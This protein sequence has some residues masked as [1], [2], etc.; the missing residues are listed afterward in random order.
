[1]AKTDVLELAHGKA[2]VCS[3]GPEDG[4]VVL[5]IHGA[6]YPYEVLSHLV[7]P[8]VEHGYRCIRFDLYGRGFSEWDGTPLTAEILAEQVIEILDHFKIKSKI[9]LISFSNADLVANLVASRRPSQIETITWIAPSG[10]DRRTVNGFFRTLKRVP[11]MDVLLGSLMKPYFIRRMRAHQKELPSSQ[12]DLSKPIYDLAIRS[13]SENPYC[14]RAATSYLLNLPTKENIEIGAVAVA[15]AHIPVM[16][17][18]FGAEKDAHD[19]DLTIFRHHIRAT[20]VRIEGGTH[21]A[22]LEIPE[23]I[24]P[25]MLQFMIT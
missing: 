24:V 14:A 6:S 16:M 12:E 7:K 10:T 19:E 13:L 2:R 15:A 9:H 11:N 21:M 17:I 20:E 4:R 1:V 23:K 3:E 18:F 8:I 25:H 22:V 5:W